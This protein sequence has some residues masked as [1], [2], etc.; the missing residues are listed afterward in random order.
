M[1]KDKRIGFVGLGVMGGAFVQRLLNS[2]FTPVVYDVVP[3]LVALYTSQGAKVASSPKELAQI[4]DVVLTSLPNPPIVNSVIQGKDG[5]LEG[6]APGL[7]IMDLSTVDPD[8]SRKNYK[9]AKEKGVYYLDAPVS[10]GRPQILEG[11]M[12]IMVG[13]DEE[14]Y[15]QGKSLL[16]VFANKTFYVGPSGCGSI[17]K[18]TNNLINITNNVIALEG[19]VFGVK[20]GCDPDILYNILCNSGCRSFALLNLVPGLLKRNF[21]PGFRIDLAKKDVG[22]A[23]DMAK[24]I[25]SPMFVT[26]AVNN[27][28]T[29][30]SASGYG[31]EDVNATAKMLEAWAGVEVKGE[32]KKSGI[33][34]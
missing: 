31:S 9:A 11:L 33:T 15:E 4:S 10:G 26:S 3:E 29:A 18:L 16:E 34:I 2:G 20:S 6:A 19:L 7:V 17:V 27:L 23:L 1:L 21:E 32:G 30:A 22:L 25:N 13:G 28:L 5:I 14:I 24:T 12:T 8:T